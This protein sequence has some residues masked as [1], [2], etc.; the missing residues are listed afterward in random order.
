MNSFFEIIDPRS[1]DVVQRV[2]V[3][4]VSEHQQ[5]ERRG[6]R[7]VPR[8]LNRVVWPWLLESGTKMPCTRTKV[9]GLQVHEWLDNKCVWCGITQ[10]GPVE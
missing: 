5:L 10:P 9:E 8:T 2:A 6:Y 3:L 7:I 1:D 4:T